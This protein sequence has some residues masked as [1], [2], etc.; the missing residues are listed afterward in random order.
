MNKYEMNQ[1]EMEAAVGRP[2]GSAERV[3]FLPHPCT[4]TLTEWHL[5]LGVW[6]R[7]Q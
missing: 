5:I 7:M 3:I 2:V 1:D 4:G 6:T